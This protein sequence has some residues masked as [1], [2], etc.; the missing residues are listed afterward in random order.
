MSARRRQ[1]F[2]IAGLL[3]GLAAIFVLALS[4]RETAATSRE[5]AEA[6][7]AIR[8][9]NAEQI[10][11]AT[12][13][14]GRFGT[15]AVPILAH[16]LT[17]HKSAHQAIREKISPLFP[18]SVR[19]R[20]S[21][22]FPAH[23]PLSEKMSA[24]QALIVLG[25]NAAAAVPAMQQSLEDPQPMISWTAASALANVGAEGLPPLLRAFQS[26]NSALRKAGC[27]GL[28]LLGAEAG[29]AAPSLVTALADPDP[30]IRAQVV[31]ALL[32][33]G[34]PALMPLADAAFSTNAMVRTG[35]VQILRGFRGDV[36]PA[37]PGLLGG[38]TNS[39]PTMRVFA[40]AALGQSRPWETN[41]VEALVT[42]L[43][44]PEESVR[45]EAVRALARSSVRAQPA[46]P[47]L[48]ALL[49]DPSPA[50]RLAA[51]QTL[52]QLARF[53]A[54]ALPALQSLHSDPSEAVRVAASN[55]VAAIRAGGPIPAG[56]STDPL[57]PPRQ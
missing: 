9:G 32:R 42:L 45:I 5:I 35:A 10:A 36:R 1:T 37:M 25:T 57:D 24:L 27:Y 38:C 53:S 30:A 28:G 17:R 49:R 14:L 29:P 22:M 46:F 13:T 23:D 56:R 16:Q 12:N 6:A 33:V 34:Q 15:R 21:R 4:S 43:D 39:D 44:D 11:R 55:S 52:G 47:R 7:R 40:A 26:T 8:S 2:I 18:R 54:S 41:V 3:L 31:D 51:A 19:A 48:T 50:I 20:I